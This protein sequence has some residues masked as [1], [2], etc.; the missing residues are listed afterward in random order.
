MRICTDMTVFI[1][2]EA[3]DAVVECEGEFE[4]ADPSVGYAGGWGGVQI[5]NVVTLEGRIIDVASLDPKERARICN[6]CCDAMN[7]EM[8][9]ER[10]RRDA[11][12]E[13]AWEAKRKGE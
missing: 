12:R 11:A 10:D 6:V 2:G 1:H 13:D 3:V 8:V 4:R 7:E 9:S 5:R